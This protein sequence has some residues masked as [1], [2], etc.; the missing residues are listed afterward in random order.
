MSFD[1]NSANEDIM[2]E[3]QNLICK[4]IYKK[5]LFSDENIMHNTC[6]SIMLKSHKIIKL[7]LHTG[8]NMFP[9]KI[10]LKIMSNSVQ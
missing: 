10:T 5:T 8:T 1:Q 2:K 6:K 3:N 4:Y 7:S 9:N